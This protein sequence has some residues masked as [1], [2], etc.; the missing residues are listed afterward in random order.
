[1]MRAVEWA[2]SGKETQEGNPGTEKLTPL[3][4]RLFLGGV[5]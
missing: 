2:T 1:M 3:M 4:Y 5:H